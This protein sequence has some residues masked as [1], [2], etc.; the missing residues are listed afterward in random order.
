MAKGMQQALHAFFCI[1]RGRANTVNIR[2]TKATAD[3]FSLPGTI[4]A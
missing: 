1:A 3:E 4:P 2:C